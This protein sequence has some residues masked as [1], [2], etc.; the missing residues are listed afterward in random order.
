VIALIL[1]CVALLLLLHLVGRWVRGRCED[2]DFGLFGPH[3]TAPH[4]SS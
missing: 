3:D 4:S 1:I 2:V